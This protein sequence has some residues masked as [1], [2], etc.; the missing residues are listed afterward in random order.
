[1]RRATA[2]AFD[3]SAVRSASVPDLVLRLVE[4]PAVAGRFGED[5]LLTLLRDQRT[6]ER[7]KRLVMGLFAAGFVSS[8]DV[9]LAFYAHPEMRGA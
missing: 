9:A 5:E 2:A 6:G 4:G 1:M 3:G 7:R 8:D